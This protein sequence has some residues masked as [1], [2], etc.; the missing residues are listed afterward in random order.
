MLMDSVVFLVLEAVLTMRWRVT[1]RLM[2][3]AV[4]VVWRLPQELGIQVGLHSGI[5]VKLQ[6]R[7]QPKPSASQALTR[8]DSFPDSLGCSHALAPLW[9]LARGLPQLLFGKSLSGDVD[10]METCSNQREKRKVSKKE[11]SLLWPNLMWRRFCS[12]LPALIK[13]LSLD[14]FPREETTRRNNAGRSFCGTGYRLPAVESLKMSQKAFK[15]QI[16]WAKSSRLETSVIT[17]LKWSGKS[18]KLQEN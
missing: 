7:Y 14:H 6:S 2:P 8:A 5:I 18:C 3:C 16:T 17:S 10:N 13:L 15:T 9:I 1:P 4:F 11:A 12:T